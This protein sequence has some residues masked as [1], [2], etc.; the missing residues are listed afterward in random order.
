MLIRWTVLCAAVAALTACSAVS[1][2]AKDAA[3]VDAKVQSAS[4]AVYPSEHN[5]FRELGW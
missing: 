2:V 4:T 5:Q 1:P 3:K